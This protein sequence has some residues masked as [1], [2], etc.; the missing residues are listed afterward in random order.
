MDAR[1]R[2]AKMR[3]AGRRLNQL[4]QQDERGGLVMAEIAHAAAHL[5]EHASHLDALMS[6]GAESPWVPAREPDRA[7]AEA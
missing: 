7:P 4:L 3:Q 5:M 1:E 2:L 6:G